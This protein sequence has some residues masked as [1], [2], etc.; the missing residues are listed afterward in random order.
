MQ[1]RGLTH[2][3]AIEYIGVKRR[4]FDEVWRPR[5]TAM[6]QGS[7]VIFD[8]HD[9]DKLFDEF[10]AVAAAA[11]PPLP[12]QAASPCPVPPTRPAS[13]YRA[14]RPTDSFEAVAKKVLADQAQRRRR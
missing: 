12:D 8:R 4:T 2:Q 9:I 3:E 1:K 10:K 11:A 6:R 7:C 5:L 13:A 14:T